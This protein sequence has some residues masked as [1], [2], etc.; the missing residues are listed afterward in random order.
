MLTILDIHPWLL[1]K[2]QCREW[3]NNGLPMFIFTNVYVYANAHLYTKDKIYQPCE[4]FFGKVKTATK[5]VT[6]CLGTMKS[7]QKSCFSELW[8]DGTLSINVKH[9]EWLLIVATKPES[10]FWFDKKCLEHLSIPLS[11]EKTTVLNFAKL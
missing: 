10:R 8:K 2:K 5:M 4:Q 7:W 1:K 3:Q 11:I 9:Y 6:G